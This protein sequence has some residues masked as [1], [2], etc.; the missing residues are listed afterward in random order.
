MK[1]LYGVVGEGMGHAMR[2]R[3]VIEHLVAEGHEVEIMASSRA[4]DYLAKRF[5]GVNRIHGF[6]IITEENQVRRGMTVLSNVLRGTA[7]L[8]GQLQAY[9][10]LTEQFAPEAVI[11]DFESWTSL[12]GESHR[13]PV[14][15]IDNMQII[16]RCSHPPEVIEGHRMDFEL[17]KAFVKAKLPMSE[18]FFVTTFFYPPVRKEHTA[19]FPPILR[20]EILESGSSRGDH[21]VVY[22]TA[23]GHAGLVEALGAT[24]LECRVYGMRRNLS[25]ELV[26]GN[27]RFR[28]FSE[29]VFISDLASARAVVASAGFTLMSECVYL[30]KP[31]LA[32]PLS[33][34][35]EQVLNARYLEL[36][37]YGAC[38]EAVDGEV[39][40]TFVA[41]LP[42]YEERLASY[43]QEG[44]SQLLDALDEHLD[45]AAAGLYKLRPF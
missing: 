4:A 36:E 19:L 34:Q 12:Y 43:E 1:I 31:L 5:S 27:L 42:E 39:V 17:V 35:F 28:P 30:H 24:G 14:F 3:V 18:F 44:N 29:Q 26:E 7:A 25:E 41:K 45:R 21:V 2:S 10:E 40:R 38:A 22:Q 8:P 20:P 13:L 33:G 16:H 6:H 11:S 9:F 32:L 15:S 37:G 23:E